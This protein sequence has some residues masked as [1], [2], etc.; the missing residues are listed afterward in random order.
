[1]F[2]INPQIGQTMPVNNTISQP[3]QASSLTNATQLQSAN[4]VPP[5]YLTPQTDGVNLSSEAAT[6][7]ANPTYASNSTGGAVPQTGSTDSTSTLMYMFMMMMMK[8]M[9]AS[10]TGTGTGT[11]GSTGAT[12]TGTATGSATIDQIGKDMAKFKHGLGTTTSGDTMAKTGTGDC[13]AGADYLH[14]RLEASGCQA[15]IIQYG[16]SAAS[17][18]RSV[19]IMQNGQWVDFDYK[20]YGIDKNFAAYSHSKFSVIQS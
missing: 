14:K 20:K 16:T 19:Q 9:G 8:M 17:N 10:G 6:A 1:M 7:A 13:W 18:H 12:G 3:L 4:I 5:N 11:T 2:G 15:R